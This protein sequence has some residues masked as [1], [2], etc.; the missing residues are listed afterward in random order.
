MVAM[1]PELKTFMETSGF[2]VLAMAHLG[3]C[4][5]SVVLYL[6][7][8]AIS[9]H[10]QVV[11]NESELSSLIG[12]SEKELSDALGLLSSRQ[13]IR[14]YYGDKS[15]KR[16][17]HFSFRIGFQFNFS[18]WQ[19]DYSEDVSA[20]DAIVYPFIRRGSKNFHVLP[21][22]ARSDKEVIETWQRVWKTFKIG[23][24][25]TDEEE[26]IAIESAKVLVDTHPIDQILL[27]LRHFGGRIPTLSLLASSWQHYQE[28]FESETQK[29]DI[30]GARHKHQ[31][32]DEKLRGDAQSYLEKNKDLNEE[33][34]TVLQV[35]IKHRHPRRQIFWAY[36][37]RSRYPGLMEF[38]EQ[39]L[40]TMLPVTTTG[41]RVKKFQSEPD[42]T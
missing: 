6:I 25:M 36:Q 1:S 22:D 29:V 30:A 32:L 12:Y 26:A 24:Q 41:H 8:C 10:D 16:A 31:E 33:E 7:N 27:M 5:Y 2:K 37:L 20:P 11:T 39:N 28:Q 34:K 40:A 14:V 13:I 21:G 17:S 19:F 23:R 42:D 9:G 35:L 4:E 38:F 18:Q 15:L 3:P